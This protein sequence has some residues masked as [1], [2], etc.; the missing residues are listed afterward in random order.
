MSV[1]SESSIIFNYKITVIKYHAE[2]EITLALS[3][4]CL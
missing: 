1:I 3:T 4:A 2:S